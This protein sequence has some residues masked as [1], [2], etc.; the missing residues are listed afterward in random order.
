MSD[1]SSSTSVGPVVR[2]WA[3]WF[4][5]T[6]LA[7]LIVDQITKIW[8]FRLDPASL[9]PSGWIAQHHNTGVAW[10][11]GNQAPLIV[12]LVTLLLIPLLTWVWWK[13]FRPCGAAENLAFGAVLGGALGNA[14]DRVLTQC[15]QLQGVRD[16]IV[17]DLNHI[18]IN[19]IWPTFNVADAGISCGVVLL[20]LLSVLKRP[21]PTAPGTQAV[22]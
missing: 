5:P 2:P 15:G 8:I 11:I 19:Y 14:I 7:V 4:V 10:G 13:Q 12:T 6:L 17:V 3:R 20:A 9:S 18:G 16:F 22:I 1:A 21:A